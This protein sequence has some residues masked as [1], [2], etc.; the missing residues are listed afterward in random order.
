MEEIPADIDKLVNLVELELWSCAKLKSLP[1]TIGKLEK[2]RRLN[3]CYCG[4]L[5]TIPKGVGELSELE[6]LSIRACGITTIPGGPEVVLK[7]PD[8]STVVLE[9][10]WN[11][12]TVSR[13]PDGSDGHFL[14]E[15]D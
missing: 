6:F 7:N 15:S 10:G 8:G 4:R 11:N 5:Q 2:L 13:N 14:T 9:G 3:V 12:I 1:D